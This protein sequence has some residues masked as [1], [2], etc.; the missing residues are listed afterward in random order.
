MVL[1][2]KYK[3]QNKQKD[4]FPLKSHCFKACC[5]RNI[6]PA[7]SYATD[8]QY[9][10]QKNGSIISAGVSPALFQP[11][12]PNH[13]KVVLFQV[14]GTSNPISFVT[15]LLSKNLNYNLLC[16][17]LIIKN[18]LSWKHSTLQSSCLQPAIGCLSFLLQI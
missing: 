11:L 6:N 17:V 2:S 8:N 12:D 10:C 3:S 14:Y 13:P 4:T 9:P 1:D 16:Q 15:Q 18:H 5:N 7:A